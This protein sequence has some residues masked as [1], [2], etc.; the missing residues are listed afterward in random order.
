[1]RIVVTGAVGYIGDVVVSN[2]VDAG[3]RIYAVD[4]LLYTNEYR[5]DDIFFLNLDIT[6]SDFIESLFNIKP[7]VIIHLAA[8]VGD[9]ACRVD[10]SYTMAI[11]EDGTYDIVD[12]IR[13]HSPKTKLIFASTCSVFGCS[14]ELLTEESKTNPLSLYAE[15][16]LNCENYIKERLENYIIFRLGTIF[17]PSTSYG[18]IRS[19]LVVNILSYKAAQKQKLSVYGGEQWRPLISVRDVGRIFAEACDST[20]LNG[21]FILSHENYKIIDIA[22]IITRAWLD[23]SYLDITD[24]KFEDARNYKVNTRKAQLAGIK[25]YEGLQEGIS[26]MVN[27][28]LEGRIIDPWLQQYNNKLWLEKIFNEA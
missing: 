6:S 8:L 23:D 4:N 13:N 26:Y 19:D 3:H 2:L 22:K 15:T 16:K 7:D 1:M 28:I 14:D 17:G 9:G 20:V 27:S 11:N 18:R 21:T 10:S 5:R 24:I 12:W 25:T